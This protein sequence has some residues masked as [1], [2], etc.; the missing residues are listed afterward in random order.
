VFNID[1]LNANI[2]ILE[3]NDAYNATVI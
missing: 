3:N 1:C 2:T